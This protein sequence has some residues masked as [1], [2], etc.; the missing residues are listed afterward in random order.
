MG[1]F[2]KVI[3]EKVLGGQLRLVTATT[4]AGDQGEYVKSLVGVGNPFWAWP[5]IPPGRVIGADFSNAPICDADP[6]VNN[7][8]IG[9]ITV[10][11]AD[12]LTYQ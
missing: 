8:L 9:S 12:V 11:P 2:V 3:Y 7:V 1:D 5:L 4:P 10:D 6:A